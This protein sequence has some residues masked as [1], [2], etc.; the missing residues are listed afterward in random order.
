MMGDMR[1]RSVGRDLL[2]TL[3]DHLIRTNSIT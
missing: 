1:E 2:V 3:A